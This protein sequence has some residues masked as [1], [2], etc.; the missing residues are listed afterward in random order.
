MRNVSKFLVFILMI[1]ALVV[2]AQDVPIPSAWSAE[3]AGQKAIMIV[4]DGH[5]SMAYFDAKDHQFGYTEGG[6]WSMAS[7]ASVKLVREYHTK[8]TAMV[9]HEDIVDVDYDGQRLFIGTQAWAVL[10]DGAPGDLGGAWMI[11]GR[12]RDGEMQP[13]RRGSRI[14]MKIMSG[15]RFQW[16]AYD[17]ATKK[18][19]GSGGGTY[20]STDGKYVETIDF[21][22][23][24]NNRVGAV[25]P[26]DFD[27]KEGDWHHSGLSSK[28]DP[29]YE[30]WSLRE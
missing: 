25:L 19:S 20:T 30:V 21:F 14:T 27:L 6:K 3:I 15:T 22:S 18:F 29:I 26:F 28:G 8:D 7:D 4:T 17:T 1:S 5:F 10:D 2:N 23:K 16:I 9:G 11:T 13:M 12:K 24:D